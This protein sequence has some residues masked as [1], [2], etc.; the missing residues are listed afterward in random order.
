MFALV[1]VTVCVDMFVTVLASGFM[2][3]LYCT[4]IT[5]TYDIASIFDDKAPDVCS[6][7]G[8]RLS[9]RAGLTRDVRCWIILCVADSG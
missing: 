3:M 2:E 5:C 4:F 7:N 9:R 6:I 8:R 1:G